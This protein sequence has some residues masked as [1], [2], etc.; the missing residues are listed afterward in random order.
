MAENI[1]ALMDRLE[2]QAARRRAS[3]LVPGAPPAAVQPDPGLR[4]QPGARVRELA[5]GKRATVIAGARDASG[6]QQVYELE[7]ETKETVFRLVSEIAAD[8]LPRSP[9]NR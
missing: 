4:Y 7:L 2:Q 9:Q 1:R 8:T 5:S 3:A 6:A